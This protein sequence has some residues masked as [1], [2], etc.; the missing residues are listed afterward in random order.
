MA[1]LTHPEGSQKHKMDLSSV[2]A[3][4]PV[5]ERL[6]YFNHAAISPPPI[7]TIR[8]VESQ[9]KDVH[10]NGST[11]FRSWLAVKEGARELL[12]QLLG[13]RPEQVAFVR[14]TSD[15]LST[16]A[17]GLD[18]RP[19]ENIVTFRREFPS[20]IYPWLRVRDAFGVEV[21]S[22]DGQAVVQVKGEV[23]GHTAPLLETSLAELADSGTRYI[24]LDIAEVTSLDSTGLAALVRTVKRL[25]SNDGRL[26][27]RSPRPNV[28][29][30]LEITG[31]D[32]VLLG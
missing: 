21:S 22:Q 30:T 24:V 27:L 3:L 8:A 32:Q 23:D 14:N 4:F 13:A 7:T 31:L 16:V 19:G 20:N 1:A 2:R 15:A 17:N 26:E 11:N 28:K 12:A 6:I 18:W 9:L 25:R 5:T 29:K 10:E